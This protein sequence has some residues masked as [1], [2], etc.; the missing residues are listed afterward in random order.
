LVSSS[1]KSGTPS[2]RSMM[3]STTASGSGTPRVMPP[4]MW[5][6]WRRERRLTATVVRCERAGQGGTKAGRKVSR[7]STRAVGLC[8]SN[9][10]SSSTV[11]GSHQCRSS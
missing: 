11:E 6:A 5:V 1:T 10:P 4:I 9:S 2:A 3:R 8:A 7:V